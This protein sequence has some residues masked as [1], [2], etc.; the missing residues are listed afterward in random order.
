MSSPCR[1]VFFR[2]STVVH[3]EFVQPRT[4]AILRC[5]DLRVYYRPVSFEQRGRVER[6]PSI[7]GLDIHVTT[8]TAPR[9]LCKIISKDNWQVN[10]VQKYAGVRNPLASYPAFAG[11]KVGTN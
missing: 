1:L 3:R 5:L 11:L 6:L 4:D 7:L 9:T 2:R 8:P 10:Y